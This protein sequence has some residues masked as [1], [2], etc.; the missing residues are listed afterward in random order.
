M[1]HP[2][3]VTIRR[4]LW[5]HSPATHAASILIISTLLFIGTS[6]MCLYNRTSVTNFGPCAISLLRRDPE[7]AAVWI[8]RDGAGMSECVCFLFLRKDAP[9]LGGYETPERLPS[10]LAEELD[11]LS[12]E[13]VPEYSMMR[14]VDWS[15]SQFVVTFYV[16][17]AA[18]GW[19]KRW[20]R[21]AFTKQNGPYTAIEGWIARNEEGA[22]GDLP[23]KMLPGNILPLSFA[24]T[25][26]THI[27]LGAFVYCI[28]ILVR[29]QYR[30]HKKTLRRMYL[31]A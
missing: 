17:E 3:L 28:Y 14:K 30:R 25:L 2:P 11:T 4:K 27:C 10:L 21:S 24:I 5:K 6:I 18:W 26:G 29:H 9:G 13:R 31:S 15:D 7:V 20:M 8:E 1:T 19:P 23:I 12:P 22:E 16:H